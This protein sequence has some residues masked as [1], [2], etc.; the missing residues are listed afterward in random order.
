MTSKF[1]LL[2]LHSLPLFQSTCLRSVGYDVR[3]L[4]KDKLNKN[5]NTMIND[6]KAILCSVTDFLRDF[7]TMDHSK[8]HASRLQCRSWKK[9]GS[10][11]T[12][13]LSTTSESEAAG[14]TP[15]TK[16]KGTPKSTPKNPRNKFIMYEDEDKQKEKGEDSE[17]D[18]IWLFCI[19]SLSFVVF[20]IKGCVLAFP[21]MV[22]SPSHPLKLLNLVC[23]FIGSQSPFKTVKP[24]L[25]FHRF[26]VT[27]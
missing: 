7:K 20:S 10:T 6:E 12:L 1:L 4:R 17:E 21:L 13:C 22:F 14:T 16:A 11:S 5:Y 2:L 18:K 23:V 8:S 26:P 19:I 25:L 3:A 24:C 15:K 9:Q 27:L